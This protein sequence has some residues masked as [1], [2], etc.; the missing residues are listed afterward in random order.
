M[1]RGILT[2]SACSGGEEVHIHGMRW[3]STHQLASC[4]ASSRLSLPGDWKHLSEVAPHFIY[5]TTSSLHCFGV[6]GT[7]DPGT[8]E[9]QDFPMEKSPW[10]C[11]TDKVH[12][13]IGED[14]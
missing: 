11:T 9:L 4:C 2:I 7:G 8:A 14:F 1:G 12:I 10:G 5:L 13:G 3:N 6:A